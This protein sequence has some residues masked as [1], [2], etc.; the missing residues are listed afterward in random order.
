MQAFV[1]LQQ[2]AVVDGRGAG[3]EVG[4]GL[5]GALV[6]QPAAADQGHVL[7][8][9]QRAIGHQAAVR[10]GQ[11]QHRHQHHLAQH[12]VFFQPDDVVGQRRHLFGGQPHPHAE[13]QRVLAGDGVVHQVAEHL[14][15]GTRAVQVAGAGTRHHRLA[16]QALFVEAIAQALLRQ[17]RIDAEITQQ[18]VRAHELLEVGERR[19]GF[20]QVVVATGRLAA[21]RHALHTGQ[22]LRRDKRCV[23]NRGI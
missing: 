22:G 12:L 1:G 5:Q 9:D 16:D 11:V 15:V 14:L 10:L 13:V 23:R 21:L 19:V 4:A 20:D 8:L 18:V 7:P 3:G 6:V 17:V 2:A